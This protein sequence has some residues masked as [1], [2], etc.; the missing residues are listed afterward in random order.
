MKKTYISPSVEVIKVEIANMCATSV[1]I[2][3]EVTGAD[4]SMSREY[5]GG[6]Y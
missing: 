5:N 4:A 6:W 2:S 1:A 3:D